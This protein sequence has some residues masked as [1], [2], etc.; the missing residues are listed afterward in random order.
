MLLE[1]PFLIAK[2]PGC[3]CFKGNL[4]STDEELQESIL[5]TV[6]QESV[7][8][9]V[10]GTTDPGHAGKALHWSHLANCSSAS[11]TGTENQKGM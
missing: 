9:H 8:P 2:L 1:Q 7:I 4:G 3:I 5:P 10:I 6:Q 11:A